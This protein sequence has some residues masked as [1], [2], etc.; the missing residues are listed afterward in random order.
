MSAHAGD[1]ADR[2][3]ATTAGGGRRPDR[4]AV[5]LVTHRTPDE[6]VAALGTLPPDVPT[7]VVDCGSGDGTPQRVR[8]AA[9]R[10]RV[11]ELAN[12]GFGRGANAGVRAT[13]AEVVVVANADVRFAPDAVARLADAVL[14]DADVGLVG[15]RLR[16]ADGRHQASA[17][18]LP[19]PPTALGHALLGRVAPD[20]RW[21]RRYRRADAGVEVAGDVG[22]VSGAAFAVRR[23]AFDAVDGFDPGYPLYVEDVDLAARLRDAGWRVRYDPCT[24]VTHHVGA[25]T[26]ARRWRTLRWHAVGLDRFA[27]R[28]YLPARGRW[29]SRPL[30]RLALAAWVTVTWALERTVARR[31]AT[32]GE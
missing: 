32:T 25:S 6:V 17:R 30:L 28:R 31:R 1:R 14:G 19:D 21:T 7:V 11:L 24:T 2:P 9:L 20:N 10:A 29:L 26:R 15:P 18:T 13:D 5:V 3:A 12:A 8:A 27:A 23:D 4:V 22:W 16:F